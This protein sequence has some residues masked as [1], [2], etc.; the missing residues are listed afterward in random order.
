MNNR[1]VTLK[2]LLLLW[3][4][5]VCLLILFFSKF[6]KIKLSNSKSSDLQT[7]CKGPYFICGSFNFCLLPCSFF[8]WSFDLLL[9]ALPFAFLN[10][11]KSTACFDWAW[12][13]SGKQRCCFGNILQ[14]LKTTWLNFGSSNSKPSF[15]P[16]SQ[17]CSLCKAIY[18][19]SLIPMPNQR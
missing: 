8:S 14:H 19:H 4:C 5:L 9:N 7:G 3:T 10:E 1:L 18:I 6:H 2:M 12:W 15:R 17:L 13:C 11:F 16:C